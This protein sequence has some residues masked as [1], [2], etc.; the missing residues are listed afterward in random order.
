MRGLTIADEAGK[1]DVRNDLPMPKPGPGQLRVAIEYAAQNPP[2]AYALIP[3]QSKDYRSRDHVLGSDFAGTIV[4]SNASA[5]IGSRV[6]G[7]VPGD[8]TTTGTFAEY[9]VCDA[10]LSVKPPDHLPLD[11]L[12]AFSFSFFTALHAL[13]SQAGLQLDL[14]PLGQDNTRAEQSPILVWGAGTAC[15]QYAIQILRVAGYQSI[16]VAGSKSLD[17]LQ[18]LGATYAFGREDE[19]ST[20]QQIRAQWPHLERALDCHAS[21]ETVDACLRCFAT[22]QEAGRR[23]RQVHKLLP[24]LPSGHGSGNVRQTFALI[25]ALLG[26]PVPLLAM[27]GEEYP[28]ADVFASDRRLAERWASYDQGH[29]HRLL[30]SG[31]ISVLPAKTWPL[32][33]KT[34]QQGL[35]GAKEALLSM[36]AGHTPSGKVVHRLGDA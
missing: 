18:R 34:G 8:T 33:D 14:E 10:A 1:I 32:D 17:A 23:R 30:S 28:S 2:D 20:V 6:C 21:P 15:G 27:L 24:S 5:A 9:T 11:Q 22:D 7:W 4:E 26:R 3:E 25:H 16:A 13:G 35:A 12:A 31:K 36:Y 29:L 19:A